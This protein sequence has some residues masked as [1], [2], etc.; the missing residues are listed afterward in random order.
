MA[1]AEEY[2]RQALA[3]N[4]QDSIG[5]SISGAIMALS[6]DAL[7]GHE[8]GKRAIELNPSSSIAHFCAAFPLVYIGRGKK[9]LTGV[10]QAI[11]LSPRDS[12]MPIYYGLQALAY[13]VL[14]KYDG[15]IAYARRALQEQP[16]N[17]RVLLRL[18]AAEAQ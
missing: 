12:M 9:T 2:C 4:P 8:A 16:D 14:R 6:G 11:C 3:L 7:R 17:V 18:A 10:D 5:H 1:E 15:S 13:L